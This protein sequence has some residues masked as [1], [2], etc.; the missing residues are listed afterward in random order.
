MLEQSENAKTKLFHIANKLGYNT[1]LD[2]KILQGAPP[3]HP[4]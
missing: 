2:H 3:P 4:R 1:I